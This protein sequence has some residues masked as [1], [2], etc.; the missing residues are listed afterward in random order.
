MKMHLTSGRSFP[1]L[2][3]MFV[4]QCIIIIKMHKK[5]LNEQIRNFDGFSDV[6]DKMSFPLFLD[7][8][9]NSLYYLFFEWLYILHML[10]FYDTFSVF[11]S[12][13]LKL[14]HLVFLTRMIAIGDIF[15]K[16]NES[17]WLWADVLLHYDVLKVGSNKDNVV[18]HMNQDP[19][20]KIQRI[21]S[22]VEIML[23]EPFYMNCS[24][25]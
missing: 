2:I 8:W 10:L 5:C 14:F 18:F 20:N 17:Y 22:S 24:I 6:K 13:V 15:T 25:N 16:N 21:Q 7:L 9:Y 1:S 23:F 3:D 19:F 12:L 11:S 4:I